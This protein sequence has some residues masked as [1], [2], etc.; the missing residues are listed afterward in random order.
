[1]RRLALLPLM[2]TLAACGSKTPLAP[3]PGQQLPVAPYGADERASS[4]ELLKVPPQAQPDRSVELRKRS[5][6]RADDPFDLPPPQ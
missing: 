1:M 4:A 6:T 3:P 2:L 5:E